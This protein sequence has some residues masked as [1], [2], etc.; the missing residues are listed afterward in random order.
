M[1]GVLRE[2]VCKGELLFGPRC[3]Y[4][5]F[6]PPG[7][8]VGLSIQLRARFDDGGTMSDATFEQTTGFTPSV[9]TEAAGD[10]S[11]SPGD[12]PERYALQAE[13]A[14]GGMG[15]IVRVE[16]RTL[17]RTL[18]LKVLRKRYRDD[19]DIRQR[20][21]DEAR[22]AGQLQHPGVAPVHDVGTLVDGRPFFTMKL[23]KGETLSDLL[24]R[25]ASPADELPRLLQVFQ[26]VAQT[27]AFSHSRGIVHRD[28]KPANV[29]VGAFGEVQ[30]MDWGLAKV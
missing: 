21:L 15:V 30:V 14:R 4:A 6:G 29:M 12:L 11:L 25:R 22:I 27:I 13:V 23:V 8:A 2:R 5:N 28:L 17:G 26:A 20:F 24:H 16:D 10:E 1:A 3:R 19:T 18:A 9:P 7:Q